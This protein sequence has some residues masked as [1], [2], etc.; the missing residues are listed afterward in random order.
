MRKRAAR[1][2]AFRRNEQGGMAILLIA[3]LAVVS[4][5]ALWLMTFNWGRQTLI[6]NKTKPIVDQ[7]TRAASLDVDPGELGEGRL[8][9]DEAAGAASFRTYLYRNLRLNAD[10]APEDDSPLDRPPV[11]HTLEFV[12][13]PSYPFKL[14]RSVTL[15]AGTGEETTR[16][17]DVTLYG[18]SVFAVVEF[19]FRG[20]GESR[21]EPVVI[22]S[23][24]SIRYR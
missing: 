5:T 4:L 11:V 12:A 6:L 20:L 16:G 17:V 8:A 22:S 13:A 18:P 21:E 3:L 19:F 2:R 10:G 23:V 9:W 7:A 15:H 14:H 1:L 24:S